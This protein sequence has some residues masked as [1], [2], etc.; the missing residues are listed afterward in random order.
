MYFQYIKILIY[1]Y[2]KFESINVD[3]I[4]KIKI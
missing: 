3:K 4:V 1:Y 2:K